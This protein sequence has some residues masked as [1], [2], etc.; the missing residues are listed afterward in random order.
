[1]RIQLVEDIVHGHIN[2]AVRIY[3]VYVFVVDIV[4]QSVE[5]VLL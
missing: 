5:L 2:N 3:L 1:M 4:D